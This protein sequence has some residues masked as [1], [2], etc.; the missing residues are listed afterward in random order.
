M[1]TLCQGLHLIPI[2]FQV[3]AS[4]GIPI[5]VRAASKVASRVLVVL[6]AVVD[7][8]FTIHGWVAQNP[9]AKQ[10]TEAIITLE[11][12]VNELEEFKMAFKVTNIV[13]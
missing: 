2:Y 1:L 7:V 13:I 6:G 12:A 8:G 3:P 11:A 9:T 10:V 5:G 4:I